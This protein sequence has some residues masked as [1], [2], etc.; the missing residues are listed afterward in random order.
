MGDMRIFPT[1]SLEGTPNNTPVI[2]LL[3]QWKMNGDAFARPDEFLMG[4]SPCH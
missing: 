3:K 1:N 4:H 2:R